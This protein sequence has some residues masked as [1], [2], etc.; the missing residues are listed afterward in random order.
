MWSDGMTQTEIAN[1][2]GVT[3]TMISHLLKTTSGWVK[4][5]RRAWTP[6]RC[7]KAVDLYQSGKSIT[8]IA[9]L[10]H[11]CP[12]YVSKIIKNRGIPLRSNSEVLSGN[13]NPAWKGGRKLVGGYWYRYCPNHPNATQSAC[14]LE[15]RLV[16]EGILGRI[17]DKSEVVHHKNG[18][19]LDNRPENL[20]VFVSNGA[21]LA[22][23]LEG[24]CP[25]WSKKG[26]ATILKVCRQ[27]GFVTAARRQF[28]GKTPVG[29]EN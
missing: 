26:K 14:V 1:S 19:T 27:N 11:T 22:V 25:K 2:V 6:D 20:E 29:S 13:K 21:H 3:Q 16:M 18:D 9:T 10:M 12:R 4:N 24:K 23:S 17:L 8:V 7:N 28:H 5:N 15:H